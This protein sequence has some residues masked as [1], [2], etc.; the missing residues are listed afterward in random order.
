MKRN[1]EEKKLLTLAL[2]SNL[3]DRRGSLT[4]A[5][6]LISQNIG[7][8]IKKSSLYETAPWGFADQPFFLNCVLEVET[9]LKPTEIIHRILK[10]EKV[11][12]R[13]RT[14]KNAARII[15]IDILFYN[16]LI[17]KRTNLTIP[18]PAI[19]QRRFILEP[20]REMIPDRIHPVLQKKISQLAQE[21][22]DPLE[23]KKIGE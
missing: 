20:L 19:Q 4:K 7:S 1:K 5:E 14:F 16:D 9:T 15:D 8:I 18:H 22:T 3:G 10:I 12:G 6:K 21:C 23:V 2:G 11:M 17:L 13:K